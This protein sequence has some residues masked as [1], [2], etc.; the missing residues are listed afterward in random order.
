[1]L[2]D[3]KKRTKLKR[4][5]EKNQFL[6]QSKEPVAMREEKKKRRHALPGSLLTSI[7]KKTKEINKYEINLMFLSSVYQ[8]L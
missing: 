6:T 4:S 8:V 5:T 1:M 7:R 3:E 2:L